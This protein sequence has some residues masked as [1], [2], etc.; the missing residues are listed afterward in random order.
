VPSFLTPESYQDPVDG[1]VAKGYG[2]TVK[3]YLVPI[4]ETDRVPQ[5][6]IIGQNLSA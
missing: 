1:K 2:E 5:L 4:D 6:F 3:W